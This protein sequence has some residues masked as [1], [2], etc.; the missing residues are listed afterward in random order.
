MKYF[1]NLDQ[2]A[3]IEKIPGF[4]G[5]FVHTDQMTLVYWKVKAGAVLPHHNHKHE[6]IT[7]LLR[8]EFE[9][10]V[11]E[12]VKICKPGDVVTI[13]S[14]V[15]HAGKALQECEII[16]VFQPVREDFK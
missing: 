12:E 6:Q 10:K 7:T 8:G 3:A 2:I 11:G 13:P 1:E 16:D 4:E 14:E 5:K 15:F 9:M